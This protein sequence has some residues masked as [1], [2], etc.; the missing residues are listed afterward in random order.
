MSSWKNYLETSMLGVVRGAS[1]Q[2][3]IHP[4]QTVKTRLQTSALDVSSQTVVK[5]IWKQKRLTGFYSGLT[6]KLMDT[7]IKQFWCW[8]IIDKAPQILEK[9]GVPQFPQMAITGLFIATVDAT[10]STPFES[11]KI[12]SMLS[13]QKNKAFSSFFNE[14]WKSFSTNWS[15]LSTQWSS[16]LIAQKYFRNQYKEI[17][18]DEP[19]TFPQLAFAGTKTALVVSVVAAPFDTA[20]TLKQI[21]K[22]FFSKNNPHLIRTMYRGLPF[23]AASLTIHNIA[24]LILIEKLETRSLKRLSP[25]ENA[26]FPKTLAEVITGSKRI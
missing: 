12:R 7:S 19:L 1:V 10:L 20:N 8:P 2:F 16:F 17:S 22:S 15:R 13:E 25:C 23:S 18:N 14:G 21:S 11:A 4:L 9:H 3:L 5:E 24:S 6:P 26:P